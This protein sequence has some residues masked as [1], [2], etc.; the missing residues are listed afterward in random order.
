MRP[1]ILFPLFA[2]VTKLPGVG[3]RIVKLV[4]KCVGTQLVD[5][6]WHLPAGIIDR[7]Y[8]P[9]ISDAA[10]GRVATMTAVC[11]ASCFLKG[12]GPFRI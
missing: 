4:E 1:E 12:Q 10:P 8:A 7:R 5:L 2:P 3:P 9:T 11:I 6:L